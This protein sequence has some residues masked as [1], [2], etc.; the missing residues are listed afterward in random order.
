MINP[1]AALLAFG[2]REDIGRQRQVLT[3]WKT[4]TE[5]G[6]VLHRKAKRQR[7]ITDTV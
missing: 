3:G 5:I 1:W 4:D 7:K 2:T 6:G